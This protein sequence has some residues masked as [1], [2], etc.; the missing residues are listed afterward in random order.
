M[1]LTLLIVNLGQVGW[2]KDFYRRYPMLKQFI[3]RF[4]AS[5]PAGLGRDFNPEKES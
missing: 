3:A 1:I 4:S 2:I 5:A